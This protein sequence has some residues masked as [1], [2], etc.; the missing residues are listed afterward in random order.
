[1][2]ENQTA[3]QNSETKASSYEPILKRLNESLA[4]YGQVL[5]QQS[6]FSAFS[7]AGLGLS[8]MPTIQNRR[9][10]AISSLPADYTKEDIGEFLRK[11]FDSEKELRSTS[12]ILKWTA[13]PYFKIIKSY[14]DIATYRHYAYA[15]YLTADD[16][17]THDY[18]REEKLVDKLNKALKPTATAHE[19]NGIALSQGKAFYYPRISV[20]KVHNTVNYAFMQQLPTDWCAIIGK[21]SVSGWT[22]SFNMMYFLQPGTDITQ[23]GELFMP[24]L[25]DFNEMFVDPTN[26]A[27]ARKVAYASAI[28]KVESKGRKINFYPQNVKANAVGNPRVFQQNGTWFYYVSLPVDKCWTFEID[29]TTPAVASPFSGLLITYSQQSD[30]EQAQLSL[31]LNPLIKIFTGEIPYFNNNG[32]VKE[33]DYK[34][35]LGGRAMFES[36]FNGLMQANS[37]GGTA[38]FTAPVENIK[39]HDYPESANANEIAKS[40]NEYSTEKSGM[41]ALI[42]VSDPKAGQAELSAKLESR[43]SNCIYRQFEKMINCIYDRLNL[44][45]QWQFVM[46]GSIYT[47]EKTREE[48]QKALDKGDI[49]VYPILA[50]LDGQSMLDKRSIMYSVKKS[51][52]LDLLT[53]PA[54]SYTQSNTAKEVGRPSNDGVTEGNEKSVDSGTIE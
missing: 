33:D 46:F 24:Y 47:D 28:A 12:E 53:P 44:R 2:A 52:F 54:T 3:Q 32:T 9:I 15:K 17:E 25:N 48:A 5:S 37:T 49:S 7:R 31:L 6:L 38:F 10:K 40:F 43:Y 45:Y 29:D 30:Y 13:Y 1:M 36:F 18:E 35:S 26:K 50:A 14:Q 42:P 41:S 23:Y 19:I 11:P 4:S 51:G 34:L 39:S 21:N 27:Q 8:N 22:I 20:D 16:G